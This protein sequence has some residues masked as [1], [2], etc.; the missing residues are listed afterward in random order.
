MTNTVHVGRSDTDNW[1]TVTTQPTQTTAGGIVLVIAEPPQAGLFEA[2]WTVEGPVLLSR[3]DADIALLGATTVTGDPVDVPEGGAIRATLDTG[4]LAV[5]SWTVGVRLTEVVP[6]DPDDPDRNPAAFEGTSDPFQVVPKPFAAGDEIAVS[7]K[8]AV[9]G[10]T[11]DEGLWVAIRNSTTALGFDNY[12]RF[13]D[14]VLCDGADRL[15]GR[16]N[17]SRDSRRGLRRADRQVALP[18][19]NVDQ[20]RLLKAA[21]EVFLMINCGT[22]HGD[23]RNLDLA[24]ESARLNRA[25]TAG[26]LEA[27]YRAYLVETPDGHGGQLDVLP[28]L[29]L[30]RRKLGDVPVIGV[31][32]DDHDAALCYG[33]LAEKL[34]NPCFLELIWSFWI[35]RSGLVQ[36]MNAIN[37]RFQNRAP[38]YPGRDPLAGLDIDPLRPLSNILWGWAQDE[39]HRLTEIRREHEYLHL[40]GLPSRSGLRVADSRSRFMAAFHALLAEC[41]EFYERDDNTVVIANGFD[42]LNA[43]KETHL[44]LTQGAHN[45]YGDLPWTARHEM[46]MSQWI[47]ARTEMRE[48]LPSRIMV[49]S[50]EGWMDPVDGMNRLQ[51]WSD[52]TSLHYRDLALSGEQIMLSIRFGAWTSVSNPDQ[53]ANWARYFRREVQQYSHAH[54]AVTG[55]GVGRRGA[56]SM[57]GYAKRQPYRTYR[58]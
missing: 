35:E 42:V 18:F 11:F 24:D 13:M 51:G 54:R 37:W 49:D 17:G 34:T 46:L 2:E 33:I 8:R 48:F 29:G 40:Y 44:L 53:A 16:R 28:Y 30:V 20:Y 52:S 25:V 32:T 12:I 43:L 14:R 23:F 39:Q 5:G 21:T 19:V 36:T 7:L 38:V 9:V 56:A 1:V 55:H 58:G 50:P 22:D 57:N 31:G 45:Q 10:P 47:L 26:D 41:M 3:A 6:D 4:R 15:G 27:Q